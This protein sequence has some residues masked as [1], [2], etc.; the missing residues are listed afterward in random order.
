MNKKRNKIT[1]V[2][3]SDHSL[4]TVYEPIGYDALKMASIGAGNTDK[5][6]EYLLTNLVLVNGGKK[7]IDYFNSLDFTKVLKLMDIISR[8]ITKFEL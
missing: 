3:L 1:E 6:I 5:M 4:A 7:D 8:F 2:I